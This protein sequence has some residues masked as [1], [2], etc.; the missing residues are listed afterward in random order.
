MGEEY[1]KKGDEESLRIA[2]EYHELE[3]KNCEENDLVFESAC[4]CRFLG[5]VYRDSEDI[6]SAKN[7]Y[8]KALGM[9]RQNC[10][11]VS[12][13]IEEHSCSPSGYDVY[14]F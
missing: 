5:D 7:C 13:Y 10:N 1:R 4:S 3:L 6:Q 8:H 2:I 14:S 9:I 12:S 11:H